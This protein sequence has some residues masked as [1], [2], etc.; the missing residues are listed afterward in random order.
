M[1]IIDISQTLESPMTAYPSLPK[2]EKRWLR[3]YDNGSDMCASAINM[4]VHTGTHVDAP[5][6][7]KSDTHLIASRLSDK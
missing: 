1:K 4:A 3:H 6:H 2:Y 5:Y 7:Y